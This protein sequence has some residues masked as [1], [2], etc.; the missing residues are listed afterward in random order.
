MSSESSQNGDEK[1]Q[2]QLHELLTHTLVDIY[3]GEENSHYPLHEKLLCHHSPFFARIFYT[4][5]SSSS[6]TKEFGLPEVSD[7]VFALFVGWLYSCALRFPEEERDIGPLLDLY[8][9][10]SK[11]Q[12]TGLETDIVDA[13]RAYYHNNS[14][15]PGL[16]R[17]Q[18]VYANTEEDNVMREMMV[19]SVA[20]FLALSDSIP[21]HWANALKK[22]GQLSV[23][24]IRSIQEW[25]LEERQV[26]DAREA[27]VDRGRGG[28]KGPVGFSAVEGSSEMEDVKEES[29]EEDGEHVNGNANGAA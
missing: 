19:G 3:V 24:I 10:A 18:Y 20:R 2:K 7:E 11:L 21:Q 25:H 29:G 4:K 14:T 22:N 26:P 15:Y 16:R 12:I 1:P 5:S 6:R 23:D 8:F 27:S 13:V 17:V 9:L 28:F